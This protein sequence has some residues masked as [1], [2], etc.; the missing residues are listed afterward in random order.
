MSSL[1]SGLNRREKLTLGAC[2]GGWALDGVDITVYSFVIPALFAAWH[3]G[4]GEAGL[5]GS[6]SLMTSAL[7]GWL[8]GILSDRYGRVRILQFTIIWFSVF[9]F[10][11]GFTNN[12]TEMLI[13]R[14][15]QGLGFGGEWAAGAILI[16]EVVRS[17]Y[18]SRAVGL[19]Q[20][21][22]AIGY[23][24]AA[25]LYG[26]V[27]SLMPPD[28]AWR[29]MFWASILPA[30]FVI[31]IRT[32]V[33]EPD[34]YR[35]ISA[36]AK[37]PGDFLTIFRRP[38]LGRVIAA[39][40]V[41][42]GAQS[43]FWTVATWLPTLL[44]REHGLSVLNTSGYVGVVTVG[45]FCG[46]L[47]SGYLGDV[48][49]RRGS[50]LTMAVCAAVV[51]YSYTLIP[52]SNG[53]M[54]ILGFPLGFFTQGIMGP[55]GAYLAELFPTHVRGSA[56]GFSYNAGRAIAAFF[57]AV[58][59]YSVTYMPLGEA[60]GIFAV[61]AYVIAVVGLIC[62]PETRGQDLAPATADLPQSR[63]RIEKSSFAGEKGGVQEQP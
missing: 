16:S 55:A 36:N 46:F 40:M 6:V 11:S 10:L 52:I 63:Q 12:F 23:G 19:V 14:G 24:A 18:R 20:G 7:G 33:S 32:H 60:V 31:Y 28:W 50:M 25:L 61:A 13:T 47:I 21:G 37:R 53:L 15:L 29:M 56:Q 3:I 26:L 30:L 48:I 43:G 38:L 22:Y 54:L 2:F 44:K 27:F 17:E 45:A 49:G 51:V 58:I 35:A 8:A 41:M 1:L 39:T 34:I 42:T 62:L 9:T 59:G 57:P 5:L 4:A